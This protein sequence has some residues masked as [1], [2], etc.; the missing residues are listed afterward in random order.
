MEGDGRG[1]GAAS[2]G[3]WQRNL[4]VCVFGSFTTIVAMTIL[5][6]F[7]PLYVEELGVKDPAAIAEWSGAAYGAAFLSAAIFAPI[8]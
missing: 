3:P 8:W 6:P 1:Q 7:L 2:E 4:A 5:L